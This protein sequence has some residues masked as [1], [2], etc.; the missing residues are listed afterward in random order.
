VHEVD[1]VYQV[2]DYVDNQS[3]KLHQPDQPMH[4]IRRLAVYLRVRA[5]NLAVRGI[6]SNIQT[7][8]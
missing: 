3:D 1:E 6:D 8:S 7:R 4:T 2:V 5:E